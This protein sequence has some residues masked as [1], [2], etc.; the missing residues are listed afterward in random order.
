[1]RGKRLRTGNV[2]LRFPHPDA[3]WALADIWVS[4]GEK[5]S[6]TANKLVLSRHWVY[7]GP[8]RLYT[9][10]PVGT[11]MVFSPLAYLA[12]PPISVKK[13]NFLPLWPH[14]KKGSGVFICAIKF[15]Q[16]Q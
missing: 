6:E 4:G 16:L 2:R 7:K 5:G 15:G 14:P 1:M 10:N 3:F 11:R 8:H 9:G 13:L 12:I